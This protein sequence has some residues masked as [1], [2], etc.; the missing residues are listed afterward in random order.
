MKN[1]RTGIRVTQPE[2]I[3][4]GGYYFAGGNDE[5][6]ELFDDGC[7]REYRYTTSTSK[8]VYTIKAT[9]EYENNR[10]PL[11]GGLPRHKD[12]RFFLFALA[13]IQGAQV[14]TGDTGITSKTFTWREL[15]EGAGLTYC[16][17][18][19]ARAKLAMQRYAALQISITTKEGTPHTTG[20]ISWS[21]MSMISIEATV[22]EIIVSIDP[23]YMKLFT[24]KQPKVPLRFLC[25]DHFNAMT[26]LES[27]LFELLQSRLNKRGASSYW[28]TPEKVWE[29]LYG[30]GYNQPRRS[31][32]VNRIRQALAGIASKTQADDYAYRVDLKKSGYGKAQKIR[33]T[34]K[35]DPDV[36]NHIPDS[37]DPTPTEMATEGIETGLEGFDS[38]DINFDPDPNYNVPF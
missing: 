33:F 28:T 32:I 30:E 31:N 25:L 16:G 19:K 36:W 1:K 29:A 3:S 20:Y 24:M 22:S 14:L 5:N 18:N 27:R 12:A 38:I 17:S 7:I 26:P 2:A 21:R 6:V 4:S 15:V 9:E 10:R 35:S 34:L 23:T 37:L 13:S 11:L 8:H